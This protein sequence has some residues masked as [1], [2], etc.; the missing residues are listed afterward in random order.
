LGHQLVL[1]AGHVIDDA[2]AQGPLRQHENFIVHIFDRA[3]GSARVARVEE[4]ERHP[5]PDID[6]AVG[7]LDEPGPAPP[8]HAIAYP[9]LDAELHCIGSPL[10]LVDSSGEFLEFEPRFLKG[11]TTR[12]LTE[13]SF[14]LTAPLMELSYPI[15]RG[16]S[17]SPIY[18]E[19]GRAPRMLVGIASKNKLT[20]LAEHE[21]VLHS[22]SEEPERIYRII[23]YGLAVRL[24]AVV[25]WRL[26]LA[27]G[28]TLGQLLPG[29]PPGSSLE[30]GSVVSTVWKDQTDQ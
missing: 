10:D 17:G 29:P 2:L 15:P 20:Y 23:E 21:S 7:R 13:P 25:L 30:A 28:R 14:D 3:T 1:T 8:F 5:N 11:H 22:A 16:M 24:S 6:L 12:V 9:T 19:S 4:W 18:L 27:S 26:S